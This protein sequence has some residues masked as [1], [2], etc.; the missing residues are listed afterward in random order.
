MG[1]I[2]LVKG[3][4]NGTVVKMCQWLSMG[5]VLFDTFF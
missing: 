4:S 3:W 1:E 5:T 2:G